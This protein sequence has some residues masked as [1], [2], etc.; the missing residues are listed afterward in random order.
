M[1]PSDLCLPQCCQD[2]LPELQA[3]TAYKG[4]EHSSG[5]WGQEAFVMSGDKISAF[6][7]S[8]N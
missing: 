8:D 4:I 1:C 3:S 7:K 5:A 6:P 2:G